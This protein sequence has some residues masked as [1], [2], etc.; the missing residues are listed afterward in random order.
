MTV[1]LRGHD[2][3]RHHCRHRRRHSGCFGHRS[4]CATSQRLVLPSAERQRRENDKAT[5]DGARRG[6]G[7][8]GLNIHRPGSAVERS[9]TTHAG[10]C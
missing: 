1:S 2:N 7:M 8:T 6:G 3:S 10:T 4:Q 5:A 9:L